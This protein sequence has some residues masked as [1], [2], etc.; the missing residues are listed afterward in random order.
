MGWSASV[1][2]RRSRSPASLRRLAG[3]VGSRAPFWALIRVAVIV[4]ACLGSAAQP[5]HAARPDDIPAADYAEIERTLNTI[6]N[7]TTGRSVPWRLGS[8]KGEVLVSGMMS[9]SEGRPCGDLINCPNACRQFSYTFV[10]TAVS[11]A[12]VN[13]TYKG[14]RCYRNG[15][16]LLEGSLVADLTTLQPAPAPAPTPRGQAAVAPSEIPQAVEPSG[17]AGS[18]SIR[19]VQQD[20]GKLLYYTEAAN[21]RMSPA[22]AAAIQEFLADEQQPAID[23]ANATD[24]ELRAVA[25][26]AQAALKRSQSRIEAQQVCGAPANARYSACARPN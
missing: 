1:A 16:W 13:N 5:A 4:F 17:Q 8:N 19:R 20:L 14:N 10:G 15:T 12:I 24:A 11:G 7:S 3:W 26:R 25:A 22:T 2:I 21:G 9:S 6:L 18:S 23:A